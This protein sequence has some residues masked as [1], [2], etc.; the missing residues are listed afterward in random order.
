MTGTALHEV[1][2][3]FDIPYAEHD[4]LRLV[5]DLY[6]PKGL[7]QAPCVIAVHGGAWYLGDRKRYQHIGP[8]LAQRGLAVFSIQY[9]LNTP[10]APAYPAAVCDVRAAV[11]FVRAQGSR[12]GLDSESIAMLGDSAGAHLAALVA[13]AGDEPAFAQR[14]PQDAHAAV[15][16]SVKAVV[17]IYGV[18]DMLAQWE[19]DQLERSRD[20][21]TQNFLGA[22][23]MENR[24]RFFEASPISYTT[25]DRPRTRF[26][27]VHGLEDDIV[28]VRQTRG[29][30]TA[31]KRASFFARPIILA[32]TG[33]FWVEDPVE[34]PGSP[35][36]AIAPRLL[37][38]LAGSF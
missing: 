29:F 8:Y 31:L 24:R 15:A 5:G 18:Y 19:H 32:G 22:S 23:P 6:A 27:L 3:R 20:Q 7:A 16:A 34:E 38:F 37:R 35:F 25:L 13:L 12:L 36:L 14:Y 17:G 33:H 9:R 11:Q 10:G 1:E 30:L 28:D 2:R 21:I 4:G 26:L